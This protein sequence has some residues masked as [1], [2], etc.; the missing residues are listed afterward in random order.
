MRA[1]RAQQPRF[2]QDV[3][4]GGRKRAARWPPQDQP[5]ALA[6]DQKGEVGMAVAD[7]SIRGSPRPRPR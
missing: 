1:E 6:L 4:G 3:V 5:G 2:A 7:R